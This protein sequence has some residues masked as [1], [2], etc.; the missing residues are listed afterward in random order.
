MR[1][2]PQLMALFIYNHNPLMS[3]GSESPEAG[4]GA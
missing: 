1:I 4:I 2:G 3:S